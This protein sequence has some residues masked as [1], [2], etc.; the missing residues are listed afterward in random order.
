MGTVVLRGTKYRA[1]VRKAGHKPHSK[2]FDTAREA[3]RWIRETEDQLDSMD[4]HSNKL[5]LNDLIDKYV[6]EI[7]P[8][9]RMAESHLD[10]DIPSIKNRFNEMTVG[11]LYGRGLIDWVLKQTDVAGSTAYWHLA[12]LCGV[13]R[14]AEFHWNIKVPWKDIRD[15]KAQLLEAGLLHLPKER[16]R[17]VSDAEIAAI[18]RYMRKRVGGS[19]CK[20]IDFCL[21]SCMR[22]GEVCRITWNE[23][24]IDRRTIL[25]RDRKHPRKKFGNDQ[26]IPLLRGSFEILVSLPKRGDRIWPYHP[27]YL[28]KVFR[29][30]ADKAGIEDVVLHDLRHEGI[31]RMFEAGYQIHEV[32]LVSGHRDWKL[33]RRYTH[34]RPEAL[35]EREK[36]LLAA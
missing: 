35:V 31:T 18:K 12:R 15:A 11:D 34:L 29:E 13:L 22:V 10:H 27:Q 32:A 17:R 1:M 3:K 7:A 24:D 20:L 19:G 6:K 8:K 2:T 30:C 25:I 33:L 36:Q 4:L 14:Q 9:R 26:R 16:D 23:L 5:L 21:S 28:S